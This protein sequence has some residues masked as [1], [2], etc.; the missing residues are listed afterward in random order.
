MGNQSSAA[1]IDTNKT[2]FDFE[3]EDANEKLISLKTFA[4]PKIKAYLI[5]NVASACGLTQQ[6]YKELQEIYE[7]HHTAGLQIL[8]FPCN[9]F[10][11]QESQCNLDIQKFTKNKGVTF[12]VLGKLECEAGEKTHPLFVFLKASL[13]GG[14]LGTSIK[15]NFS[16]FLCDRNGKP[17][18][19]YSPM[20]GP[21]SFENDLIEEISKS[22]IEDATA[23]KQ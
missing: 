9:N 8:A 12:P 2:I 1:T 4:D 16:K 23:N 11:S 6:N 18:K 14:V 13:P 21:L 15:W 19:R 17:I 3:V 22:I 7:K 20:Q 10:L 5:V